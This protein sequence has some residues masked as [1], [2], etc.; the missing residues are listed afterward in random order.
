MVEI[1]M[2][3]PGDA[4]AIRRINEMAFGGPQEASLVEDLRCSCP[5]TLSLVAVTGEQPVGHI[6]F[7]PA[8]IETLAG[9]VEGMALAPLAV[10]PE[11]QRRGI[12]SAL[13]CAGLERLRSR[14]CPF[15]I[16][17]GHPEY[18]PRFGFEPASHCGLLCQWEGVPDEAFMVLVLDLPR[19]AGVSGIARFREEF[20]SLE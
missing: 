1:R 16:V 15:V 14:S 13:V 7:S 19:M 18:Y 6:L 4:A 2:E 5:D 10:L 9:A 11:H 8:L 3:Q 17:L 12:G 20:D